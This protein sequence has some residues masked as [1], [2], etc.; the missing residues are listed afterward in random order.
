MVAGQPDADVVIVGGG[1]AG[2]ALAAAL[3]RAGIDVIVLEAAEV[4]RDRVRGETMLPW[5]VSEARRLGVEQA[6]LGAGAHVATAWVR[7]DA[8][9]PA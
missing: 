9:I 1:I 5:G 8:H 6:L 3:G 4:Y 2:T 7:Y